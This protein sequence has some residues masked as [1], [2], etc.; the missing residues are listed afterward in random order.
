MNEDLDQYLERFKNLQAIVWGDLILDEYIYTST[1][2]I[3]REAPVLVTEFEANAFKLG[4]GG[5]VIM[6]IKS[7]G[8]EP[9]P[10]GL[11]GKD[12]DGA[13][14]LALLKQNN[15]TTDYLI[16]VED[17]KTSKKSRILSGGAS[18]KK[19][20]ILRID[21][22][23]KAPLK[24]GTYRHIEKQIIH[25]LE[26]LD[27]LI[28]SDYLHESV[29]PEVFGHIRKKF[30]DKLYIADSRQHFPNFKNITIATPNEPEIKKMFPGKS[31]LT[32]TDFF[33]AGTEF[34]HRIGAEGVVLKR[35]HRGM[36]VIDKNK[37]P[38]VVGIYG[39]T[40]IV[41]VTGAG[42]TVI[43]VLG[44][45]LQAGADLYDSARLANM[46][47]GIVVMKEGCYPIPYD[48]LHHVL[49]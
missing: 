10:V 1:S 3:S 20:Q 11:I 9:I 22:L 33:E 29:R 15:I 7:L 26:K 27:L 2:R 42:D 8:A 32:D 35:G 18:T 4:G 48:E 45:A 36:A 17:Y 12:A 6:N 37:Q 31:F 13:A 16:E 46:A 34:L 21:S 25:L 19:Q 47:A 30:P 14:L 23:N 49:R 44:L 40:D 39:S 43:S 24:T 5:N 38:R 41:D 28:L